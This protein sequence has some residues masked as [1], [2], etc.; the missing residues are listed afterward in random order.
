MIKII[1]KF[2]SRKYFYEFLFF[3]SL[4]I[5]SRPLKK[6]RDADK[7][8]CKRIVDNQIMIKICTTQHAITP[9]SNPETP[10]TLHRVR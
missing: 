6:E 5:T 8:V 4:Y 7:R 3:I 10:A 9:N 1:R 2:L